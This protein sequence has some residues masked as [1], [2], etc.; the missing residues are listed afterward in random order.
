MTASSPLQGGRL[1]VIEGRDGWL[2]LDRWENYE[3]MRLY[4][5]ETAIA[6][7]VFETWTRA[8]ARRQAYFDE[9]GIVHLTLI[10]PDPCLVYRDKLPEG[11]RLA[12]RTPFVRLERRLD[13]AV[14]VRCLYPLQLLVD[15]RRD[16][17]TFASVDGH[18]T[19]WGAW[20]GYRATLEALLPRVP[21]LRCLELDD[22]EWQRRRSFGSLGAVVVPERSEELPIARV[23][24]ARSRIARR[25]PTEVR[26]N[27]HVHEQDDPS[28]P[29]A[30]IFRDSAM[31]NAAQ[32]FS[33][34]F[35][36]TAYVT[37][38]NTIFYDL[39][40]REKPDVVIF[41]VGERRLFLPPDE[42]SSSDF[43]ASF[44]DLLLDDQTAIQAQCRSRS[45]LTEGRLAEALAE[46]DRVLE[47][48]EPTARLLLYRS[49]LHRLLGRRE[50]AIDALRRATDLDPSDDEAW[51][52]LA[53][54]LDDRGLGA[55]ADQ[56]RRR[57]SESASRRTARWPLSSKVIDAE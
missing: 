20:L 50:A 12:S 4:T 54:E 21:N 1:T 16:E 18:W 51:L 40:D 52:E 37:T 23:K 42:P 31:T 6:E 33:E 39:V 35:R 44:G 45:L 17:Q 41:E 14:R 13:D 57:A 7:P 19:D 10:V 47:R 3:A 2:F 11:M 8:L 29:T 53:V 5:D 38:P 34:S 32:F 15:G 26:N 22:L 56:A 43:R 55:E 30:L 36:R 48:V 25:I 46:N 24:R 27:Y 49:R 9:A 28:L